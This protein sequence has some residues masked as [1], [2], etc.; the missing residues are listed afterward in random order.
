MKGIG[1]IVFFLPNY[2]GDSNPKEV[3]F[4]DLI[5]KTEKTITFFGERLITFNNTVKYGESMKKTFKYSDLRMY[6]ENLFPKSEDVKTKIASLNGDYQ[7]LL[8]REG[9]FAAKGLDKIAK[10]Y[11]SVIS[12]LKLYLNK[13]SSYCL[14]QMNC[15][16]KSST[17][18]SSTNVNVQLLSN[19]LKIT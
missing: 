1:G 7:D 18:N 2:S 17:A 9:S 4:L 15:Y 10:V 19:F 16:S 8:T 12:S 14:K 3:D 5:D 13:I 11:S 6:L